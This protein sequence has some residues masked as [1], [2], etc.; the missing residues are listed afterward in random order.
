MKKS[1]NMKWKS[2]KTLA[3]L[4]SLCFVLTIYLG[5]ASLATA[6]PSTP[7]DIQNHWAQTSIISMIEKNVVNGYPDGTFKPDRS[8]TRAEF[9]TLMNRAFETYNSNAEAA[10]SD[11]KKNDWYY[12]QVASG[13]E[14]GYIM[15]YPDGTFKPNTSITREQAATMLARLLK[16][17]I[18]T[19]LQFTD[20]NKISDWA[21]ESVEA[22]TNANIIQGYPEG[23]FRPLQPITRAETVVVIERALEY[24]LAE[25]V[26]ASLLVKV[27]DNGKTVEGATVNVFA[28]N[29]YE[30][31][32][33]G[34][35]NQ[36]GIY[37][38]KLAEGTYNISVT[39][40]KKSRVC[41]PS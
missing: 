9:A 5:T 39:Q 15:G 23:D 25:P 18:G 12:Y 31:S 2:Q 4:V 10:F 7:T 14:A 34:T 35:T 13:V 33:T 27:T 36:D 32:K 3:V 41:R 26:E 19:G 30:P 11:V 38:V 1:M 29:K 20:R 24:S 17:D 22:V 21:L 37:T 6:A 16:L 40:G 8:V 28:K